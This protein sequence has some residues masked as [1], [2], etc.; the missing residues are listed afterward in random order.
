MPIDRAVGILVIS[1]LVIIDAWRETLSARDFL[2]A[3]FGGIG[4]CKL[5]SNMVSAYVS[6]RLWVTT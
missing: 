2:G 3:S 6:V 5:S 1:R 4:R